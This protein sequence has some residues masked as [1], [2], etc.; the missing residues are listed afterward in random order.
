LLTHRYYDPATGRFVNRD[1]I[2]YD[3]GI[4]LYGFAGGNP[5]NRIDPFGTQ[6]DDDNPYDFVTTPNTRMGNGAGAA[7]QPGL[8]QGTARRAMA[9]SWWQGFKEQLKWTAF[10]V[11]TEGFF[12]FPMAGAEIGGGVRSAKTLSPSAVS[13]GSKF[14]KT[15]EG[16]SNSRYTVNAIDMIV[17]V[18]G[19]AEHIAA[20]KS[21]FLYRVN[22]DEA[23]LMA[24]EYADAHNL[25]NAAGKAKVRFTQPVGVLGTT[26]ELTNYINVYRRNTNARGV[27]LIHGAPGTPL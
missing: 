19:R 4:N 27:T 1:P 12:H 3:G 15:A 5:V 10:D 16:L 23:V 9:K 22:A 25:W 17:H 20:G 14:I 8:T 24:A 11:L 6:D 26:G 21:Q 13:I 7:I 18:S 2:G